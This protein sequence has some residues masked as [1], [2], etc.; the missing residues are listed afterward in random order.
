MS[1]PPCFLTDNPQL[2]SEPPRAQLE[3]SPCHTPELP[4]VSF[5]PD[6]TGVLSR[7]GS[8]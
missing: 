7:W 1:T 3:Y 5:D 8:G 4:G 2:C 6:L